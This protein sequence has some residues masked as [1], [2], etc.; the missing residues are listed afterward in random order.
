M[1]ERNNGKGESVAPE[2][3]VFI[4]M[5]IRAVGFLSTHT[6]LPIEPVLIRSH[7]INSIRKDSKYGSQIPCPNT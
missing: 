2:R 6:L 1:F 3:M 4:S 5:L 7:L